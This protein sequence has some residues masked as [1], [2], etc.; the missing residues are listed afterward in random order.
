M[1][2]LSELSTIDDVLASFDDV[3]AQCEKEATP[4]GY[5]PALYRQVTAAIKAAIPAGRFANPE[6]MA[7]FDVVFASRYFD[8]LDSWR[9]G[10]T[11]TRSWLAS[12]AATT[13][14]ELIVL[15]HILRAVNA[16]MRLDLGVAAATI[17]PGSE[18]PTLLGDFQ[19]VDKILASLVNLDRLAVDSVSPMIREL[20]RLGHLDD[21][22]VDIVI[23]GVRDQSW[24][25]A[26]RLAPLSGDDFTAAVTALDEEVVDLSGRVV[27]P[28]VVVR[29]LL[30]DVVKPAENRDVCAVI[31][32]LCC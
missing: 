15:Q 28:G 23:A 20:D 29:T 12:F 7:H 32:A 31:H 13:N 19:E 9:K 17:A 2:R 22:L 24:K 5:F 26:K 10:E 11:P 25:V 18:L 1:S 4:L 6:R 30:R 16:H 3:I 8:A 14:D 27:D 21:D